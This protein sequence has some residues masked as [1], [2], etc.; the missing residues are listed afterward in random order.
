MRKFMF[1][2]SLAVA[3]LL[4][5]SWLDLSHAQKTA[6]VP[7]AA[8]KELLKAAKA[9]GVNIKADKIA[10]VDNQK[11]TIVRAPIAGIEKYVEADYETGAPIALMIIKSTVKLAVPDGSYVVSIQYPRNAKSGKVLFT[12]AAGAVVARDADPPILILSDADFPD[13]SDHGE[14]LEFDNCAIYYQNFPQLVRSGTTH[15]PGA[16]PICANCACAAYRAELAAEGIAPGLGDGRAF[17]IGFIRGQVC[18]ASR[19]LR[20]P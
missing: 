8:K 4:T 2:S 5:G 7:E 11:M 20:C 1:A 15:D 13:R 6:K 10:Y 9:H 12:N 19:P 18:A 17:G 16:D 14:V 3:I